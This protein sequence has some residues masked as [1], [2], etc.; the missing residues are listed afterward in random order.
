MTAF[1]IDLIYLLRELA[2]LLFVVM[3]SPFAFIGGLLVLGSHY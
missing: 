2:K 3:T 1:I